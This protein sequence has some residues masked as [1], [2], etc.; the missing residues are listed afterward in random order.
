MSYGLGVHLGTTSV[1]AAAAQGPRV[2]MIS[3]G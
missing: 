3:L 1:V 2:E